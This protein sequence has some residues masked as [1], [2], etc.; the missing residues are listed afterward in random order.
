[1]VGKTAAGRCGSL[2]GHIHANIE[3]DPD[4]CGY[5]WS[6]VTVGDIWMGAAAT[7]EDARV[8]ASL[9]VRGAISRS[10]GAA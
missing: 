5:I 6:V 3:Q 8:I 2:S 9:Y 1:M 10:R 4:G 7:A